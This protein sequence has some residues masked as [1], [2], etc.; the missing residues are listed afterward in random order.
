MDTDQLIVK[1][2][3]EFHFKKIEY[4][5]GQLQVELDLEYFKDRKIPIDIYARIK[6]IGHLELLMALISALH[7]A[8]FMINEINFVY[9]FG[10][11]SDRLFK[12]G[13][14]HYFRDVIAPVIN[15]M[16]GHKKFL[17]PHGRSLRYIKSNEWHPDYVFYSTAQVKAQQ[18]TIIAGDRSAVNLCQQ[19]A[20]FE[21]N[22]KNSPY[23]NKIRKDDGTLVA[24]L[25]KE[26]IADIKEG[27]NDT[28]LIVD[29]MCDGGATFI[30]E[31]EV[32]RTL[33]PDKQLHLFVIH[34]LFTKG[35]E[36]ISDHFDRIF[37]T[38]SYQDF[39]QNPDDP[40]R[41]TDKLK[42]IKVI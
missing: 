42:V 29:D 26:V 4:P 12:P 36:H 17:Q 14:S 20:G 38:N 11:R 37:T 3:E 35:L 25:S 16:P 28:I 8:D 15:T 2:Y 13:Q 32:L 30:A 7:W 1:G 24:T 21:S 6:H 34:G 19:L 10:M 40:L 22:F 9:L 5:D 39:P 31:S 23:F 18:K 27:D 33:F 41:V